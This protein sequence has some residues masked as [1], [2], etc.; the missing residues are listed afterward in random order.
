MIT[1]SEKLSV[2][3]PAI[4]LEHQ[5]LVALLNELH[6]AMKVG[7]GAAV[8]ERVLRSLV[9]YTKTHFANEEM[10]MVQRKYPGYAPHKAEHD[11]LTQQALALLQSVQDGGGVVARLLDHHPVTL[12]TMG[13]LSDWLTK[14]IC[15]SDQKYSPY[16]K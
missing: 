11:Q 10:L 2:G 14:H 9:E 15:D 7:K 1:W 16:L 5:K 3:I 12:E 4:D 13:F 8:V 6:D